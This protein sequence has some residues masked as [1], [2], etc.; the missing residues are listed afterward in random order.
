MKRLNGFLYFL[1][2]FIATG[3]LL[4]FII[5]P[6]RVYKPVWNGY[7]IVAFPS[8]GNIEPYLSAVDEY[9]IAG[10]A[11]GLGFSNISNRFSFLG[12]IRHERFP[13]TD[14]GRYDR[15]F[16]DEDSG[17]RFFYI[18]YTS[19]FKYLSLYFLNQLFRMLRYKDFLLSSFLFTASPGRVRSYC[20][21]PQH[22]VLFAM[23]SALKAVYQ[24][25]PLF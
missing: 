13:F 20:F 12:S 22:S 2:A 16:H 1:S 3:I 8:A 21:S 11:S 14:P 25:R 17:Y 7:R 6:L 5:F 24:L 4:L 15:W 19:L 9:G 18:P 10:I 23:P